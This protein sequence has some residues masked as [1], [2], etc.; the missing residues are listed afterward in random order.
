MTYIRPA[1]GTIAAL[2]ARL[3]SVDNE[4]DRLQRQRRQHNFFQQAKVYRINLPAL[5][6]LLAARKRLRAAR[7]A[8]E[9][10]PPH[11]RAE[12]AKLAIAIGDTSAL[13]Q[14]ETAAGPDPDLQKLLRQQS[15]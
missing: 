4:P 12:I 8:L 3:E 7:I 2:I 1:N 11:L 5:R 13:F 10:Q 14:F 15:G 6:A 9:R